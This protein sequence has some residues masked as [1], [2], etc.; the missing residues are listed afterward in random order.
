L[1]TKR[2]LEGKIIPEGYAI[3]M[4]MT[5]LTTEVSNFMEKI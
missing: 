2:L 3:S 1:G 4:T 5:S